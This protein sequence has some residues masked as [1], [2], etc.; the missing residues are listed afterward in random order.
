MSRAAR[1][2]KIRK[3]FRQYLT[4]G[5]VWTRERLA[6]KHGWRIE[7]IQRLIDEVGTSQVQEIHR[8]SSHYHS[9]WHPRAFEGQL[10]PVRRI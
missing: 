3:E 4:K 8:R 5:R 1:E 10:P 7:D 2:K 6:K 9:E